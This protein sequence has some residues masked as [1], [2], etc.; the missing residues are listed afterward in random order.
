MKLVPLHLA[1][2]PPDGSKWETCIDKKYTEFCKCDMQCP[3]DCCGPDVG[4]WSIR[5]RLVGPQ[6]YLIDPDQYLSL[7]C[8]IV[9][10][11]YGPAQ[12]ELT[13]ADGEL[14]KIE[15]A[16]KRDKDAVENGL[17][18]FDKD[19]KGAIPSVVLCCDEVLDQP[20]QEQSQES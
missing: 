6:P 8:C 5:Q 13:D 7:I 2:A 11:R 10:K 14:L 4:E 12:K 18:S 1:I 9:E 20:T 15:N 17:K 19:A 3:D 16:I